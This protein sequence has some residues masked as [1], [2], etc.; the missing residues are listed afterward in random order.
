MIEIRV[1]DKEENPVY[2]LEISGSTT[3]S[4][5]N[6]AVV[7]AFRQIY[8]IVGLFPAQEYVVDARI[9]FQLSGY[10]CLDVHDTSGSPHQ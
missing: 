3:S 9:D 7:V 10:S 2:E 8:F 4:Q 5:L 1:T 6:N